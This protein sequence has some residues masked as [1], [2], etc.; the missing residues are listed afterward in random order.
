MQA[1][2]PSRVSFLTSRCVSP[3]LST[4][5]TRQ[6]STS[7]IRPVLAPKNPHLTGRASQCLAWVK[8][9]FRFSESK[10]RS[11]KPQ[12]PIPIA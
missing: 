9:G 11:F 2:M 10:K 8:I 12:N 5:R 4:R 7:A 6:R 3:S 1:H